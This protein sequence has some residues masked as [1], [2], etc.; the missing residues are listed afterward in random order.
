M[1]PVTNA[2]EQDASKLLNPG[3]EKRQSMRGFDD[4]YVDIV[5][6]IIRCTHKIW[7]ERAIGLIYTHYNHNTIV[8]STLGSSHG[9]ES[10]VQSTAQ[11]QAAFPGRY[12]FGNDVIWSGND[13]DG[14]Y[15]SHRLTT[16][17]RNTGYSWLGA[18][19]NRLVTRLVFADCAVREN[20]IYEEWVL[21]DELATLRQMGFDP[22]LVVADAVK[23][24]K[25]DWKKT[26]PRG[27]IERLRGQLPPP[28]MPPKQSEEFDVEDFVR[29]S[30]HE[31]WN[32]RFL[33]KVETYYVKNHIA[34]MPGER[35]LYGRAAIG[36][37]INA[38][39]AMFPDGAIEIDHFAAL[40]DDATG[41]RVATRWTFQGTHEGNGVYGA[42]T[43]KR[44]KFMGISHHHIKN[45][46][47][48]QE[49]TLFDEIALMVQLAI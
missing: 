39:L 15:S 24:G 5:D 44:V 40:G 32:W 23:R 29:R 31:I 45:G 33:N 2:Y 26:E 35:E 46:Q 7:E 27:D 37:F 11:S 3:T 38:I 36:Y 8:H 12:L 43:G 13:V 25:Y 48:I 9:I 21:S 34:H 4:D 30:Y 16:S 10:V 14:F 41:Y 20:R 17:G 47:Y 42:P 18:P 49:W 1:F 6:Y 19:T 22:K 28:M